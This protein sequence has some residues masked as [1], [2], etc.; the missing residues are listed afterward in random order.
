MTVFW[1]KARCGWRE[2]TP[3]QPG[4]EESVERLGDS[5]V[6]SMIRRHNDRPKKATVVPIRPEPSLRS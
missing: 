6:E 2:A 5:E 3:I 1:L 4:C